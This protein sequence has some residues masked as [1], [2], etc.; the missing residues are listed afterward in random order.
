LYLHIKGERFLQ[1]FYYIQAEVTKDRWLSHGNLGPRILARGGERMRK[2][3]VQRYTYSEFRIRWQSLISIPLNLSISVRYN[4][5]E[6][7]I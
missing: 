5:D 7:D 2:G 4:I 1:G 3:Q 6:G